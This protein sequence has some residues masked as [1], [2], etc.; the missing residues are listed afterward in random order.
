MDGEVAGTFSYSP[1]GKL[2]G[3]TGQAETPFLFNGRYGVISDTDG[4]LNMR[5]RYYAPEALRFINAD[6][7]KGS[8]SDPATL[9]RYAF[10]NGS[11]ASYIDP[12]GRSASLIAGAH[13]ALD[14]AGMVPGIGMLFDAVNLVWYAAE[15]DWAN[16]GLSA[17]ALV[18]GIGDVAGAAKLGV[19]AIGAAAGA[20][21]AVKAAGVAKAAGA[22]SAA[23]GVGRAGKAADA[24]AG[25]SRGSDLVFGSSSKSTEKL[26]S[27]MIRRGWTDR[28]VREV[29]DSPYTTRK[30]TNLAQ[31]NPATAY[32]AKDGSYVVVDDV[33]KEVVQASDR[34]KPGWKPDQNIVNPYEP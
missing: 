3:R 31:G 16:V 28:S 9:N 8:A 34:I 14:A 24:G 10:A 32:Y 25:A 26:R 1:Y 15:G 30:S 13:T 20:V 7:L 17:L 5:A 27:Q 12:F 2:V 18:P 21:G 6:V 11:P 29:I 22:T 23:L 19:K 33:T 4:L